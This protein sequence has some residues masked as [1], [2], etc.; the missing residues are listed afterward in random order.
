MPRDGHSG[1]LQP[2]FIGCVIEEGEDMV[3]V[4]VRGWF[5][6]ALVRCVVVVMS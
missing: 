3:E 4:R 5:Y 1:V 2:G 6:V